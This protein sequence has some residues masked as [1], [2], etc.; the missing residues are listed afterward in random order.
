MVWDTKLL[1]VGVI[2]GLAVPVRSATVGAGNPHLTVYV[3][4]TAQTSAR[5]LAQAERE[6]GRIFRNAGIILNWVDCAR[7]TGESA[8]AGCQRTPR[9]GE[10]ALRI[11]PRARQAPDSVFGTSFLEPSGGIYADI[12]LDRV[13][14]LR[15]VD[16]SLTLEPI[17]GDVLAHEL[18]HL[19]LGTS[20][21]TPAGLMQA[22]WKYPQLRLI[23]MGQLSFNSRE[24]ALLRERVAF[25]Q[26][27]ALVT[28]T[29][30]SPEP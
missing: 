25:L 9:P 4:D 7:V 28:R 24:A 2:L 29:A 8:E 1:A 6:A 27:S 18:G 15:E 3:S 10:L 23:E 5:S 12:F 16:P 20:S 22:H 26:S 17:L 21:H 11:L 30:S 19:L 13:R 14:Q